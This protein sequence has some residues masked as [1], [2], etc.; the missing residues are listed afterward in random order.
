MDQMN[1]EAEELYR[2]LASFYSTRVVT[3]FPKKDTLFVTGFANKI[4]EA[5]EDA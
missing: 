3:S 1:K 2:I 5:L 4:Q